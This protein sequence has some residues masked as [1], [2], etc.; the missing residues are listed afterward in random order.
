MWVFLANGTQYSG[1]P[2]DVSDYEDFNINEL[3]FEINEKQY[4]LEIQERNN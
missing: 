3:E 2:I 4:K 1:W